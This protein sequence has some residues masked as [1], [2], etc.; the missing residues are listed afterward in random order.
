MVS[1]LQFCVFSAKYAFAQN[2]WRGID[3]RLAG[4]GEAE[5]SKH[6]VMLRDFRHGGI[7]EYVFAFRTQMD[8]PTLGGTMPT[9]SS[10]SDWRISEKSNQNRQTLTR[11]A[12]RVCAKSVEAI[13]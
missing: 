2:F 13:C 4:K 10:V 9:V 3:K 11:H 12:V 1:A 5:A 8:D 6:D 7:L